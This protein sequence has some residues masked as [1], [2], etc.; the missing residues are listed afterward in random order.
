MSDLHVDVFDVQLDR[1]VSSFPIPLKVFSDS[2]IR[3]RNNSTITET[4][5]CPVRKPAAKSTEQ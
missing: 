2:A 1:D 3:L 5:D 4:R